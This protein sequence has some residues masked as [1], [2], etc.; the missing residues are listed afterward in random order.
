MSQKK[1]N[2][3][4]VNSSKYGQIRIIFWLSSRVKVTRDGPWNCL[5]DR[6]RGIVQFVVLWLARVVVGHNTINI[7]DIF[8]D[9][10]VSWVH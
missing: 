2:N 7:P 5:F 8:K 3:S 10:T 4:V 9:F 6:A 1:D